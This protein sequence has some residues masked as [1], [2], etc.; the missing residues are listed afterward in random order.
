[1]KICKAKLDLILAR[2]EQTISSLRT[3]ISSKTLTKVR[4]GE[5]V[6][7]IVVGRIARKLGVDPTEI[8]E[9]EE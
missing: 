2:K 6:L 8:I 4:H 5:E 1:M 3:G 9:T 7:P